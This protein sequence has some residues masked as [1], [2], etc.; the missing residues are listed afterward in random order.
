VALLD[1][2]S[3]HSDARSPVPVA[4]PRSRAGPAHRDLAACRRARRR[5]G[6]AGDVDGL[7][8]GR[9]PAASVDDDQL[10]VGPLR[11]LIGVRHG[12]TDAEAAVAEVPRIYQSA[13]LGWFR[14]PGPCGM[15]E[16]NRFK[17][18]TWPRSVSYPAYWRI[19]GLSVYDGG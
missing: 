12:R 7:T 19:T 14:P 3:P 6:S 17:S 16:A 11:L 4:R 5:A 9:Q 13:S 1:E 10:D 8:V 2:L 18:C 15:P